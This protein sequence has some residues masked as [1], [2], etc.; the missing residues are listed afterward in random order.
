MCENVNKLERPS[1]NEWFMEIAEKIAERSTCIRRQVGCVIIKDWLI[2]STWFNW[3]ARWEVE[4]PEQWCNTENSNWCHTIHAEVNAIIN[5]AR[6]WIS[7]LSCECYVT[8]KPCSNCTRILIN[9]WISKIF[10]KLEEKY[11]H[12]HNIKIEDYI[13]TIKM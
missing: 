8:L 11:E 4:C 7:V 1:K 9:A 6:N 3:V 12:W 5:A 13:E 10:Y 2:V